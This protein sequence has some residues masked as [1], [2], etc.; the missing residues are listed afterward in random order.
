MVQTVESVE[1]QRQVPAPLKN[2]A[3]A[4][5]N[6]SVYLYG[7]ATV[8]NNQVNNN[9]YRFNNDRTFYFYFIIIFLIIKLNLYFLLIVFYNFVF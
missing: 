6:N 9:L 3:L 4:S 2:Y 7:G 8:Y 1:Q 5:L